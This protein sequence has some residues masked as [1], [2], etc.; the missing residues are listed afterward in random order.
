MKNVCLGHKLLF[1]HQVQSLKLNQ[2]KINKDDLSFKLKKSENFSASLEDDDGVANPATPPKDS[3]SDTSSV[4]EEGEIPDANNTTLNGTIPAVFNE[5]DQDR[6]YR[7]CE[8]NCFINPCQKGKNTLTS[9]KIFIFLRIRQESDDNKPPLDEIVIYESYDYFTI[10]SLKTDRPTINKS[11]YR[12]KVDKQLLLSSEGKTP[13]IQE[14]IFNRR[15]T[16]FSFDNIDS[17]SGVIITDTIRPIAVIINE[18][19]EVFL[20]PI[21][22]PDGIMSI[23]G[24]NNVNCFYGMVYYTF[25]GDLRVASLDRDV[26]KSDAPIEEIIKTM[27]DGHDWQLDVANMPIKKVILGVTPNFIQYHPEI[28][29]Y[30]IVTTT[31]EDVKSLPKINDQ[32]SEIQF[33]LHDRNDK[34]FTYDKYEKFEAKLYDINFNLLENHSID[35]ELPIDNFYYVNC[36]ENVALKRKGRGTQAYLAMGTGC[37]MGEDTKSDGKI[38]MAEVSEQK[39]YRII[40]NQRQAA[41]AVTAIS[42]LRGLLIAACG[43]KMYMFKMSDDDD[44][45]LLSPLAFLD[46]GMFTTSIHTFKSYALVND[47]YKSISLLRYQEIR[48]LNSL[49][50]LGNDRFVDSET[51]CSNL[52]VSGNNLGYIKFDSEM[53]MVIYAYDT[54]HEQSKD[55][56]GNF[57]LVRAAD[58]RLLTEVN[59]TFRIDSKSD[60]HTEYYHKHCTYYCGQDGSIGLVLPIEETVYRRLS[61]LQNFL[62]TQVWQP[63]GLNPKN[64]KQA[65]TTQQFL[66]NTKSNILDGDLLSSFYNLSVYE[67]RQLTRHMGTSVSQILSDLDRIQKSNLLI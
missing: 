67:R 22:E 61:T 50:L 6:S 23:A 12:V 13:E 20:H 31:R 44:D 15:K 55:T 37:A 4:V 36:L 63:G 18:K 60:K 33:E 27:Q 49:A 59:T 40:Y 42:S 35:Q 48:D 32:T 9:P 14:M 2:P 21:T 26:H 29:C 30:T 10:L 3:M 41:G 45:Q 1:D 16:I 52:L 25:S 47:F 58:T 43:Q 19:Q 46:H 7:I 11:F 34:Y 62:I 57:T 8:I 65:T 64:F 53:N 39:K 38:V 54:F 5:I 66:I 51:Y 56:A 17:Y 28:L 24:F